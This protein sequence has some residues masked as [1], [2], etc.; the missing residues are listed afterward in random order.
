[1]GGQGGV[2]VTGQGTL[3]AQGMEGTEPEL[4]EA[5]RQVIA[6]RLDH[7]T[8]KVRLGAQKD[9]LK[10]FLRETDDFKE[11]GKVMR[12]IAGKTFTLKD[13]SVLTISGSKG[14]DDE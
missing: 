11:H 3:P 9:T 6:A 8:A 4:E 13:R 5:A 12:Q 2:P 1:M 14:G 10:E 7:E